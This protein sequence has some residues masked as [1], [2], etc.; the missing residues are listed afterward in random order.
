MRIS[1]IAIIT[2]ILALG[3]AG[4][5]NA[6][7]WTDQAELSYVDTG[8]N[9]ETTSLSAKNTLKG[10]LSEKFSL[11]WSLSGLLA[12]SD[13]VTTAEQYFTE[14]RLDYAFSERFYGFGLG[15]WKQD[16]PAGLENRTTFGLGAGYKFLTGP[17][18]ELS[19]EAGANQVSEEFTDG[20][21]GDYASGRV[22]G[23]YAWN[24]TDNS[25]L[26]QTVEYLNDLED[27]D[28]Y[29]TN[30]ET[31]YISTVSEILSLKTSYDTQYDNDPPAGFRK[32]DTKLSVT[33][34][35]N[36]K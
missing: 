36:L 5:L 23:N 34:V 6:A 22:F 12:E 17:V 20:T 8:G 32:T 18:H 28:N 26:S 11:T 19:G 4:N 2:F 16:E 29:Q 31:A 24:I 3:L 10:P 9:T 25:K 27:S 30:T 1:Y 21:D 15:N 14:I 13:D 35:F 33:F 7:P